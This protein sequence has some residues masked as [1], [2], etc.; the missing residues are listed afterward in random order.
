MK[1]KFSLYLAS[2][3]TTV[4]MNFSPMTVQ[5]Q[6]S[7]TAPSCVMEA[8]PYIPAGTLATMAFRGAFKEEGIPGYGVLQT[9][10]NSGSITAEKIVE[11]AV[12]ACYLSN[13]YGMGENPNYVEDVKQQLQFMI[14][15]SK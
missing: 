15:Q 10:F 5:A 11:A 6:M 2:F 14:Q 7:T 8:Q 3:V 12:K 9:E 13:K 4:A 1:L